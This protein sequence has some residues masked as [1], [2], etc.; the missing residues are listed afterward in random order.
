MRFLLTSLLTL[1]FSTAGLLADDS[2][3]PP[4]ER[5]NKLRVLIISGGHP[6]DEKEF[7]AMFDGHPDITWKHVEQPAAQAYFAPDKAGEYDVMVWYDLWQKIDETSRENLVKVLEKGKPLVVLHH[8]LANYQDWPEAQKIMGGRYWMHDRGEIKK[9]TFTHNQKM[10]VKIAAPEHPIT[11]FMQDFDIEDEA[12]GNL[13]VEDGVTPLLTTEHPKSNKVIAW[14]H[15]Y[16]KSPVAYIQLGHDRL[17][18]ENRS[19]H[20]LVIQAIRW[21]AGRLPSPSEEGFTPLLRK[22]SFDGWVHMGDPKGFWWTEEGTLRS[23]SGK[24][25]EWIRTEREYSDFILKVEWKVGEG[26]NSGVFVRA[27]DKSAGWPWETGSEIQISNQP[28]DIAH[29]TGSMYGTVSVDPRPDESADVW[30][31][32]YIECRGPRY[33]VWADNIPIVDV[34]ARKVPALGKKP[35]KGFIGLQDSHNRQSYV[36][37]RKV[38]VKELAPEADAAGTAEAGKDGAPVWRIGCQAYSFRLFTFFEAI[39][40]TSSVGLKYIEAYPGQVLSKEHKDVRFDHNLSAELREKVKEKLRKEGVKLVNYGVVGLPGNEAEA[41]KVFDFARDMGIETIVSEPDA[42]AMELLDKLTAEY[43]IRI[44]IHNHPKGLTV[45]YWNPEQVLEAIKGRSERI[46]ACADTGHWPRSGLNPVEC[47]RKLD[48]RIVSLHFK[49]LSEANRQGHDVP[50]GTGAGD[51]RAMLEELKRQQ[52]SGVFSVEYEHN[53][54]N[55]LPEIARSVEWFR[56]TAGELGVKV[57]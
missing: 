48:G 49:D 47:L 41:R 1:S 2:V 31:E 8:A 40:K 10:R 34:D 24:G 15:Q 39:E 30:H 33:R 3:P 7:F 50:W 35:L 13:V 18:F 56:K 16:K 29:C 57:D 21:T 45:K 22:G 19:Y 42:S 53:W 23:E 20:R 55:S 37:F 12:Y 9:S 5:D 43:R 52:F 25:G 54:E 27:L 6:Y 28:R 44:A 36:E 4:P 38:L 26:G 32:F 11:K 51:A 14:A 46:G 17:S